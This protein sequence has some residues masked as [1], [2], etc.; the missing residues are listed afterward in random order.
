MLTSYSL[1]G[2]WT[3]EVPQLT[4]CRLNFAFII[5]IISV[6]GRGLIPQLFQH[7]INPFHGEYFWAN[8]LLFAELNC[9]SN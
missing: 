1:L 9:K 3:I 2:D 7:D 6:E 8:R 5:F 4:S